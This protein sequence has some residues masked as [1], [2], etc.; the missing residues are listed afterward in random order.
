MRFTKI[1]LVCLGVGLLGWAGVQGSAG[2]GSQ[3][4]GQRL[5]N[6]ADGEIHCPGRRWWWMVGIRCRDLQWWRTEAIHC[7]DRR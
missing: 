6:V 4:R 1:L 7:P 5:W 2:V 3:A